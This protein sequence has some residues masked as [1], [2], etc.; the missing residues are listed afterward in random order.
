MRFSGIQKL[1]AFSG[2]SLASLSISHASYSYEL[3]DDFSAIQEEAASLVKECEIE[4]P[5]LFLRI[6]GVSIPHE[7]PKDYT[8]CVNNDPRRCTIDF[9]KISGFKQIVDNAISYQRASIQDE[10]IIV[11][12]NI[13]NDP[14][15]SIYFRKND[16]LKHDIQKK[17]KV[18]KPGWVFWIKAKE[19]TS[20]I[21]TAILSGEQRL[22][23]SQI[24]RDVLS[25]NS[26]T[27]F[28]AKLNFKGEC[29]TADARN[30]QTKAF[31]AFNVSV[32]FKDGNGIGAGA[33]GVI[34]AHLLNDG[35][36]IEQIF[37]GGKGI[38]PVWTYVPFPEIK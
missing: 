4:K 15:S 35:N 18:K 30:P 37:D 26:F 33:V 22:L 11:H 13:L 1:F 7:D 6:F 28:E 25:E 17:F 9:R 38:P 32:L 36:L 23:V 12:D 24:S 3:G 21:M 16:A 14:D 20:S 34:P 19:F 5:Q 2:L 27:R 31:Q 10:K 8:T 29:V